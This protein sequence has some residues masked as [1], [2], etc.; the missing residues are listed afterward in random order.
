MVIIKSYIICLL[1]WVLATPINANQVTGLVQNS[2]THSPIAG[3]KV[4]LHGGSQT[5]ETD[6]DGSFLLPIAGNDL[7]LVAAAKG[8]FYQSQLVDAPAAGVVI[9]L[10]PVSG[11]DNAAYEVRPPGECGSCHPKQLAEWDDSP[12]A[13]AGF[14]TWVNDIYNGDGTAGGLGG[15]VYTRDSVFAH[16]NPN[17]ECAS[18][19]QPKGWIEQPFSALDSNVTNPSPSVQHG[20]SCDVC[21]KIADVDE[22]LINHPGIFPGAV[23]YSRPHPGTQVQYGILGDVDYNVPSLMRASYQPQMRASLCATC[24]QDAA[25]PDEDHSYDGVISEPTYLEWLA[26]EYANPNSPNQADCVDCHMGPSS[27][28]SVCSVI[29]PPGRPVEAVKNHRIEGTTAAYLENAV[30]LEMQTVMNQSELQVNVTIHNDQTGHHV[31]TGVTVRNMILV[32]DAWLDGG[33]P[34]ADALVHTGSQIIHDLGGVGNPNQGYFAGLPGKFYAKVNHNAAGQGPTFFTEATG[35]Q[36]DNRIAANQSD[37]TQ[38]TFQLPTVE[39][40]IRVRARLIYR[41]AFRFLVDAKNWTEDGH[42]NPLADIQ[43][44][45]FGHLMES[46]ETVVNRGSG[47]FPVVTVGHQGLAIMVTVILAI[48]LVRRHTNI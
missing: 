12:M 41:R 7:L 10:D 20:V 23:E 11:M 46:A 17:S 28:N 29:A 8:H 37:L 22:T 16:S 48:G 31:P 33:D 40:N 44:P 24:H 43:A 34:E 2:Q 27:D 47:M 15:F 1:A 3:A 39:S 35:I 6:I 32:V 21:H 14:N 26:S 13:N 38:Y 36:F 30:T 9:N 4:T 45:H 19:H 42:G 5:S 18:C 25:D